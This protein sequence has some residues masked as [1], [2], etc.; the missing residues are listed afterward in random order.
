[1]QND[2]K[3]LFMEKGFKGKKQLFLTCRRCSSLYS[4][5]N[6]SNAYRKPGIHFP[7]TQPRDLFCTSLTIS[8]SSKSLAFV[9]DKYCQSDT[10]IVFRHYKKPRPNNMKSKKKQELGNCSLLT[11]AC[12]TRRSC[13]RVL[14]EVFGKRILSFFFLISFFR[15]TSSSSSSFKHTE[16][17]RTSHFPFI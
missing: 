15:Q 11:F 2:Q 16:Q 7:I 12:P 6:A 17:N 9:T 14:H 10:V 8:S 1:M 4:T 3:K 13:R 5:P